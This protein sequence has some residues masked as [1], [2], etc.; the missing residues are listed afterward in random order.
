MHRL[1]KKR[2]PVRFLALQALHHVPDAR[3]SDSHWGDSA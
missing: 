3:L 1:H 2:E